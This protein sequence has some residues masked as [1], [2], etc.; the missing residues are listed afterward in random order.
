MNPR[1]NKPL[2]NEDSAITNG[3]LHPSNS[4]MY[5][6]GAVFKNNFGITLYTIENRVMQLHGMLQMVDTR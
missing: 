5:E 4:K 6:T 1:Y 2:Y 3:N